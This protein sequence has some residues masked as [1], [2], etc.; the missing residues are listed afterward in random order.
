[1]EPQRQMLE[2]LGVDGMSSDEEEEVGDGIQYR[3]LA[4]KWR[5]PMLT[6]WLRIF[7]ILY[8]HNRLEN[9]S[10]DKRGAFPRRRVAPPVWTWSTSKRFVSGLPINAYR[11]EW[12]EEQFDV[13]NAVHPAPAAVYR[14]DPQLAQ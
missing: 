10:N 12:L 2:D 3:I 4:P 5:S 14:H 1:M 6:P 7:D 8:Q 13:A 11:T 9:N